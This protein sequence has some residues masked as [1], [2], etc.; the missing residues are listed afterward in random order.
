MGIASRNEDGS[1]AQDKNV[2]SQPDNASAVK[3]GSPDDN[4]GSKAILDPI[5]WDKVGKLYKP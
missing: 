2:S 5:D 3:P 4:V 1:V